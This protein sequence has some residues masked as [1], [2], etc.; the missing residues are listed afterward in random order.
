VT[1]TP[2]RPQYTFGDTPL[3]VE[4]LRLVAEV[5]APS[6]QAFLAE[7]V[8]GPPELAL[9]VGCGP[10]ASTRLVARVTGAARTVG[11]DAS[12]TF[13]E[14]AAI[15]A[16][17]RMG[18]TRHDVTTVPL[19]EAPADLIYCRLLLAHLPEPAAL[20][21]EWATQLTPRG[22]LLVDEIDWMEVRIPEFVAY[23]EI[24][25]DLVGSRG[26]PMYAG[27]I[28]ANVRDGPGW[29]QRASTVR[30]VPVGTAAA[31]RMF[32]MNVATWRDDTHIRE[33]YAA[34]DIEQLRR[35]LATL[36]HS[37]ATGDIEWGMRQTVY[38]A[39]AGPG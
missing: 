1:A 18:F 32:A 39:A 8:T 4:R 28:V 5:F 25:L 14:V 38:E 27:P 31:A 17:A 13:L 7:T 30:T 26:A 11:L 37:A 21:A 9:D 6:S 15:D 16:P 36:T 23:E 3:A 19:P 12:P 29:A 10:G 33:H 22:Q 2:A 20:V 34:D 24:V 35:A